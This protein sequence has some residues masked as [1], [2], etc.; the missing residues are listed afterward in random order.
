MAIKRIIVQNAEKL[1]LRGKSR[2]HQ[3]VLKLG[4]QPQQQTS[5][6]VGDLTSASTAQ[7]GTKFFYEIAVLG[8]DGFYLKSI[9]ILKRS[10]SWTLHPE[11]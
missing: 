1:S 11:V 9:A 7:G 5:Q 3:G 4:G 8:D 6:P 2:G 10:T